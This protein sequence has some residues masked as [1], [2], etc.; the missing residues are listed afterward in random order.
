[1]NLVILEI[2][3]IILPISVWLMF[4][5]TSR[6]LPNATKPETTASSDATVFDMLEVLTKLAPALI[7]ENAFATAKVR[8]LLVC[9]PNATFE[10]AGVFCLISIMNAPA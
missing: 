4:V 1:M 8:S 9:T 7:A 6:S 2:W 3:L 5:F 10:R